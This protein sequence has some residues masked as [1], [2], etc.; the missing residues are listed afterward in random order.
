MKRMA[1]ALTGAA[2]SAACLVAVSTP[3]QADTS[4]VTFR[5]APKPDRPGHQPCLSMVGFDSDNT[6][7]ITEPCPH[8][9][10]RW[11]WTVLSTTNGRFLLRNDANGKCLDNDGNHVY[12]SGCVSSDAGQRWSFPDCNRIEN[13]FKYLT[14]WNDGDVSMRA[15]GDVDDLFKQKW[16]FGGNPVC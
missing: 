1:T 6:K 16:K 5:L 12:F 8:P 14:G 9:A 15:P 2:A 11:I 4:F 10:S 7:P 3:A 13:R